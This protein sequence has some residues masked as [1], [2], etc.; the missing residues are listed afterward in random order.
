MHRRGLWG[1]GDILDGSAIVGV[2]ASAEGEKE[3][4]KMGYSSPAVD[5]MCMKM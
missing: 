4:E 5:H 1:S 2:A 3:Q